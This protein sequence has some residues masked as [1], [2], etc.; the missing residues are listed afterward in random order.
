MPDGK[1]VDVVAG[2][3]NRQLSI[4]RGARPCSYGD[5]CLLLAILPTS[6]SLI[7]YPQHLSLPPQ[8]PSASARED[9]LRVYHSFPVDQFGSPFRRAVVP[10]RRLALG[11]SIYNI[12]TYL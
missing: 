3:T 4:E 6:P 2:A 7:L 10:H 9:R 11:T 8:K 1:W 12:P 5:E